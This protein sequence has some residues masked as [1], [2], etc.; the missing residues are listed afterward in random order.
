MF[1]HWQNSPPCFPF[2]VHVFCE[3]V[4]A[5]VTDTPC[6]TTV[7]RSCR[8]YAVILALLTGANTALPW[9][10][11]TSPRAGLRH[12]YVMLHGQALL[13]SWLGGNNPLHLLPL[14]FGHLLLIS[15]ASISAE[16]LGVWSNGSPPYPSWSLQ[17]ALWHCQT[18]HSCLAWAVNELSSH[19]PKHRL[20]SDS[21]T[22]GMRPWCPETTS[23]PTLRTCSR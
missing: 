17:R 4:N 13:P 2:L 10:I 14:P 21:C 18:V 22:P 23:S 1:F 12:H 19:L 3:L 7:T 20:I 6:D 8:S 16:S 9:V 15:S 11:L 5:P